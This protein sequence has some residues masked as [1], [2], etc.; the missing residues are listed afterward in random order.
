MPGQ[1][2][3][4]IRIN[5]SIPCCCSGLPYL[6]IQHIHSAGCLAAWLARNQI[7]PISPS[8]TTRGE[9]T[10]KYSRGWVMLLQRAKPSQSFRNPGEPPRQHAWSSPVILVC[11]CISLPALIL[12]VNEMLQTT[13]GLMVRPATQSPQAC[14]RKA[15]EPVPCAR[16]PPFPSIH[17]GKKSRKDENSRGRGAGFSKNKRDG[18]PSSLKPGGGARTNSWAAALPFLCFQSVTELNQEQLTGT[19][20]HDTPAPTNTHPPFFLPFRWNGAPTRMC[21]SRSVHLP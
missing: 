7:S 11:T 17:R 15:I 20:R 2:G 10:C 21:V 1:Q 3:C 5:P 18:P 4:F 13:A 16:V 12:Q 19:I 6:Y 8:T 14:R 9:E